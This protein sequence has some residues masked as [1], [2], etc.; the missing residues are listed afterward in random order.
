MGRVLQ[1]KQMLIP[2]ELEGVRVAALQA[3][4]NI[5]PR[6]AKATEMAGSRGASM[7]TKAGDDLP[8]TI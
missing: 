1:G 8:L 6:N 5:H 2:R 4:G 3:L 7:L